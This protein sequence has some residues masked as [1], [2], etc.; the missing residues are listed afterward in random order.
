MK[1]FKLSFLFLVG[2]VLAACSGTVDI[3]K[4]VPLETFGE[5]HVVQNVS[6][7]NLTR[8]SVDILLVIDG[9]GS[10]STH[11]DNVQKNIDIFVDYL[12]QA[13]LNYHIAVTI[14]GH[15][16]DSQWNAQYD[17]KSTANSGLFHT[18]NLN[19]PKPYFVT[20]NTTRGI[21]ILKDRIRVG[22]GNDP[23][24]TFFGP[25]LDAIEYSFIDDRNRGFFREEAYFVPIFITDADDQTT[26]GFG[27]EP[28]SFYQRLIA[29]KGT[30]DLILP[31]S[32][33]IPVS[34]GSRPPSG[35]TRD[36]GSPQRIE[37]FLRFAG[38]KYYDVCAAD[39]GVQLTN[40]SE[41]LVSRVSSYFDLKEVPVPET[42]T[43]RF[44]DKVLPNHPEKGWVYFPDSNTIRLG[45]EIDIPRV[46][47]AELR[48]EYQR[49]TT[50][51]K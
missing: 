35:C 25:V 42:I 7:A 43:V 4:L 23:I 40:M 30:A 9:S 22:T 18:A 1:L 16:R 50:F 37:E 27:S 14:S 11:Q 45:R 6:S 8:P 24:E 39:F 41:D 17:V 31:Y 38:G 46:D 34:Y 49:A 26:V 47:D 33:H 48:V 19:D 29:F 28:T 20:N 13:K 21:Q 44:G 32:V 10:M 5:D 12:T 15:D 51:H 3:P 2:S 36:G